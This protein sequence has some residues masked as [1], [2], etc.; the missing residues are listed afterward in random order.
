[1]TKK[2]DVKEGMVQKGGVNKRPTTPP[3]PPPKGQGGKKVGKKENSFRNTF[4]LIADICGMDTISCQKAQ[5]EVRAY[6]I[7]RKLSCLRISEKCSIEEL[8]NKAGVKPKKIEKIEEKRNNKIT[9]GD[10]EIYA[11]AFNTKL[12]VV[13]TPENLKE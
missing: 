5:E 4:E 9:V 6:A 7:G 2:T 8:A 10:L 11:H 3:P 1:M 13:L 12:S